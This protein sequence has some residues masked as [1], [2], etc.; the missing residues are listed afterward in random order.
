MTSEP[1]KAAKYVFFLTMG[2]E[3][4]RLMLAQVVSNLLYNVSGAKRLFVENSDG[5]PGVPQALSGFQIV[6]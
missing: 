5:M 6:E 4:I 1:R 3:H 2:V